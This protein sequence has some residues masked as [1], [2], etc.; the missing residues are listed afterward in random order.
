MSGR[1]WSDEELAVLRREYGRTS[2]KKIAE[3][4]GR[5]ARS[6]H[7]QSRRLGIS[8]PR[9][10]IGREEQR[11]IVA[12]ADQGYCNACIGRAIGHE[13]HSVALWRNKLGVAPVAS[14]GAVGTCPTCVARVREQVRRM[15]EAAGV[16]SLAD[17]RAQAFRRFAK[18]SGWPA[19]LRPRAVMIL[20]ALWE[21]GPQTRRQLAD[22]IGMPWKGSRK[23][24]VSG[25]PEGSYLAHLMARGLVV[26]LGRCIA[27]GGK[28]GNVSLYSLAPGI[29]KGVFDEAMFSPGARQWEWQGRGADGA[30]ARPGAGRGGQRR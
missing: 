11:T 13:R 14:R 17:I 26:N 23:S 30:S 15:C 19:D 3:C 6:V 28:G 22:A 10:R 4:L 8:R 21:R 29:R 12:M 1:A 5:T 2:A 9:Q 27:Q 25:D 24:L 20:N 16:S 7:E 18:E